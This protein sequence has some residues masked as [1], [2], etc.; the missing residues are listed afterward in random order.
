[1]HISSH[2]FLGFNFRGIILVFEP[3]RRYKI[4]TETPLAGALNTGG[5]KIAIIIIIEFI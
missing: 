3:H 2:F 1:M 5:G 4:P